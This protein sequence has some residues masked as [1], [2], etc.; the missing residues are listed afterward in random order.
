MGKKLKEADAK[1][2]QTG[3]GSD[4]QSFPEPKTIRSIEI[5]YEHNTYLSWEKK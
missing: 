4:Q 1:H 2:Q 5:E 3:T